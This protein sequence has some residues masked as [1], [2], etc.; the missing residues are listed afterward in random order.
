MSRSLSM[1]TGELPMSEATLHYTVY[2]AT[3]A[4]AAAWAA[5]AEALG[6]QPPQ[7][8]AR[9]LAA[10]LGLDEGSAVSLESAGAAQLSAE[11]F[12]LGP[13]SLLAGDGWPPGLMARGAK[14][15]GCQWQNG[16]KT[17]GLW[18]KGPKAVT[19]KQFEA[20]ASKLDPL[21]GLHQ[22]V[23]GQQYDELL[24]LVRHHGLDPN[25]VVY[26]QPL[27]V[28]LLA[29]QAGKA[30]G[31]LPTD[32]VIA[33]LAAGASPEPLPLVTRMP[34]YTLPVFPLHCAAHAF[35]VPLMQALLDAGVDVNAV[36][37]E[38]Q[39]A[40]HHVAGGSHYLRKDAALAAQAAQWLLERGA[41][42]N[43]LGAQGSSPLAE[44]PHQVVRDVLIAHGGHVVWPAYA[45]EYDVPQ[46]QLSAISYHDHARLDALLAQA[47]PDEVCRHKLLGR[48]V[49]EG[50]HHALDRLWRPGDH[51]L[52]YLKD[53]SRR[54]LLAQSIT[55]Q[56]GMNVA[57]LRDL[58][59]RSAPDAFPPRDAAWLLAANSCLRHFASPVLD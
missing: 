48:A 51:A 29:A 33:L 12:V 22:L 32:A 28:R 25:T 5:E 8:Q 53:E 58:A 45:L 10:M 35:D 46:Q 9:A 1:S 41:Q 38:G 16:P 18:F 27:I 19:R 44:G 11:V 14:L 26:G 15:F 47:P 23:E 39:T 57:M 7:T 4:Q 37:D 52:M 55:Q 54:E 40:L 56:V 31:V 21:E 42:V 59:E 30:S 50:N 17:E 13:W 43:A 34:S 3:A 6:K 2:F 36:D 49:G 20:A 24:D